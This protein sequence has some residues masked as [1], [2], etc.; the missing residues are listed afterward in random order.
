[1]SSSAVEEDEMIRVRASF[2][3]CSCRSADSDTSEGRE[4]VTDR[5]DSCESTR[6]E[7]KSSF[8]VNWILYV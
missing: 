2:R 7:G 3:T 8:Q 1:M 5:T 4:N 6:I